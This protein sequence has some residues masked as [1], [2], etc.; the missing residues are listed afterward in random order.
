MAKE[1]AELGS[2]EGEDEKPKSK[3]ILFVIIGVVLLLGVAAAAF[4]LM[5]G[6]E[7]N[8]QDGADPNS[9]EEVFAV[10]KDAIYIPLKPAF[11]LNFASPGTR[12]FLQLEVTLMAREPEVAKLI[13]LHMPLI[14]NNLISSFSAQSYEQ[15]STPEG[16][17]QM[18]KLALGEVQ[19]IIEMEYGE[20]GVEQVLFTNFVIQ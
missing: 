6:E 16:K 20:P 2:E 9:V 7:S 3:L 18:K 14:R 17:I 15:I 13:E 11:V 8:G 5:N 19:K 12:R 4:F 1:D 10:K